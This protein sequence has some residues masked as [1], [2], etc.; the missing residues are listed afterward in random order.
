[1]VFLAEYHARRNEEKEKKCF[2]VKEKKFLPHFEYQGGRSKN[3]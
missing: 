2:Y 3:N 1:M